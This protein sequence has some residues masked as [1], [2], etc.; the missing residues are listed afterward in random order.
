MP[1]WDLFLI[2]QVT[3]TTFC[4]Q[5]MPAA[6]IDAIPAPVRAMPSVN[7]ADDDSAQPDN[8]EVETK[9]VREERV[10]IDLDER[11][12]ERGMRRPLTPANG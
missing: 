2:G 5:S 12:V 9:S 11:K 1:S 4:S 3:L 6:N 8:T 7:T 10:K